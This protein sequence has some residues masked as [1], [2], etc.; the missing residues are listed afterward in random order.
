VN[1]RF[2]STVTTATINRIVCS[3]DESAG[4]VLLDHVEDLDVTEA[5]AQAPTTPT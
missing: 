1:D 4:G 2:G 3:G 5:A